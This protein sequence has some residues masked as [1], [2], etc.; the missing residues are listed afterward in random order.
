M[1]TT[2]L[3]VLDFWF[4]PP[5]DPGHVQPRKA[6]FVKD[7][8]FDALIAQRF[9]PLIEQALIGGIDDWI[10]SPVDPLPALARV[11][12]IAGAG[13]LDR[14]CRDGKPGTVNHSLVAAYTEVFTAAISPMLDG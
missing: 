11:I 14:A 5:D 4:G 1:Q 9:G 3:E 2:A 7:A 12:V 10:T 13:V 8:A 6:W